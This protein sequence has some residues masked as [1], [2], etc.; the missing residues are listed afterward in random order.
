[1][2][3]VEGDG[4]FVEWESEPPGYARVVVKT[5]AGPE[6]EAAEEWLPEDRWLSYELH[7]EDAFERA[8]KAALDDIWP[9]RT[10]Y[11]IP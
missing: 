6:Q 3:R 11:R 1:V 10:P 7:G 8:L 4:Y 2:R 5:A 9:D